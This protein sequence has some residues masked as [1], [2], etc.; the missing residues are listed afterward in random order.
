L[1]ETVVEE[2]PVDDEGDAADGR[3]VEAKSVE[4]CVYA[5][6]GGLVQSGKLGCGPS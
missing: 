1:V 5:A 6:G 4:A 3:V 2:A